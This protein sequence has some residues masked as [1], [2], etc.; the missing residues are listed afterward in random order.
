MPTHL[1]PADFEQNFP[2]SEDVFPEAVDNDNYIDALLFNSLAASIEAIES[3]LILWKTS[4]ESAFTA[5]IIAAPALTLNANQ[6]TVAVP[7]LAVV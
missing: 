6:L 7:K 2:T 4:I 1:D 3:Y 5:L